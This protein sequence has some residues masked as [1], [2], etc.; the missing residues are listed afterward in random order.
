MLILFESKVINK[1]KSLGTNK[2]NENEDLTS[3]GRDPTRN[4]TGGR[5]YHWGGKYRRVPHDLVFLD[6]MTL[7][8]TWYWWFLVDHKINVCPLWYL[9]STDLHNCKRGRRNISCMMTLMNA[10][11]FEAKKEIFMWINQVNSKWISCFKLLLVNF[12]V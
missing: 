12:L 1:L 9:T 7:R 2:D 5:W 10:M 4:H 8:T 3:S 11:I 6:K